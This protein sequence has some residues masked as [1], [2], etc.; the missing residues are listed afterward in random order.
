MKKY[1]ADLHIHTVLSP[2]GS[3]EMS[4]ARIV[5][6]AAEK[7]LDIIGITDHNS[8]LHCKLIET[9]ALEKGIMV[10]K[11]AEVATKEEV[12]CLVFFEKDEELNAFQQFL[13]KKMPGIRNNP[14]LFGYQV[15]VDRE[16]N[17]H[18]EVDNLL[19]AGLKAGIDE[20]SEV[21]K[22]LNGM[23]IPAHVNREKNSIISQMGFIPD[24]LFYDAL[25]LSRHITVNEFIR[26]HPELADST[27]IRSSD[28]HYPDDIGYA[29]TCFEMEDRSFSEIRMALH[30]TENR[31][32]ITDE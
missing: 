25:E 18:K 21:V 17:I 27:F 10:L 3:L 16:E 6:K 13:E 7:G 14:R 19:I 31:R 23:F 32:V 30:E 12:H 29:F 20:I 28:A 26:L 22:S 9:I 11:G 2:C 24:D 5:E 15:V 8:T 4:P 1:R